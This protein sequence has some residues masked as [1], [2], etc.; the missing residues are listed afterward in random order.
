MQ[1]A[2]LVGIAP[3]PVNH[4]G[5]HAAHLDQSLGDHSSGIPID[6]ESPL[7]KLLM[8]S[9]QQENC[10]GF[11]L[12]RRREDTP[13]HLPHPFMEVTIIKTFIIC[14]NHWKIRLM[15]ITVGHRPFPVQIT[16][17]CAHM[18]RRP[19]CPSKLSAISSHKVK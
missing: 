8:E 11:E 2:S 3:P 4:D 19:T 7:H 1:A 9:T 18:C 15:K 12:G 14:V 10:T 5:N 6:V 16:D 17:G 13:T